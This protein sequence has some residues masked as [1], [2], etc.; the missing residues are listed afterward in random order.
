M[1]E[2]DTATLA[3][4]TAEVVAAYLEKNHVRPSEVAALITTVHT[5]LSGL[6]AE[7]VAL[8]GPAKPVP[9]VSIRKSVTDDY[10]ISMEDGK[11]YQSLKRH[12]AT[13]GLT[14]DEYRAKWGLPKDYSMVA[15]AYSAKRSELAK[16]TGLG[17]KRKAD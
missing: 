4:M 8:A 11:R 7:P 5:T 15:S 14:P 13:R 3:E 2:A 6:G 10:L 9:P 1:P 16:S 12:L 17:N